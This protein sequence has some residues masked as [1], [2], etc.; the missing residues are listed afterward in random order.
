MV[1]NRMGEGGFLPAVMA[2]IALLF[3]ACSGGGG[4]GSSSSSSGGSNTSPAAPAAVASSFANALK[5]NDN[6]TAINLFYSGTM[7]KNLRNWNSLTVEERK[8]IGG[9]IESSLSN[10]DMPADKVSVQFYVTYY[11]QD[12]KEL[13]IPVTLINDNGTF[14][15]YSY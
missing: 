2:I 1:R 5:S 11:D 8:F 6:T 10:Q 3:S 14:K 7:E 13:R 4:G 15:I 9:A 12:N